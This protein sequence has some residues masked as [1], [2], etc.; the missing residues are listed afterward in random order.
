[1]ICYYSLDK[2]KCLVNVVFQSQVFVYA[3]KHMVLD[4][5]AKISSTPHYEYTN[6]KKK[7]S[8]NANIA[9]CGSLEPF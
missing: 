5:V 6:K 3:S 9:P 1:M 2:C 8:I 7:H 4:H